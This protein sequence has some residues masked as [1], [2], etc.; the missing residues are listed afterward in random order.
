M[1]E[2]LNFVV[3]L[4][5][6]YGLTFI[7]VACLAI[8]LR[9]SQWNNTFVEIDVIDLIFCYLGRNYT[10]QNPTGIAKQTQQI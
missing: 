9:N 7:Y 6:L 2:K 10:I 3:L 1:F 5:S 4:C 8:K